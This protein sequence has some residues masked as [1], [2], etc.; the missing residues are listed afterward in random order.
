GSFIT[1]PTAFVPNLTEANG[2]VYS[3]EERRLDI[4]YPVSRNV[5]TYKLE[6]FNQ[7]GVKVFVS[8]DL[9]QG[10][11]GYYLGKCA[12]QA[13]YSYKAEGYFKDGTSFRQSGNFMLVR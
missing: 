4:F 5:D 6:I 7:W 9:Y 1:F 2:G 8:E 10:W 3:P 13:T 11:D 12:Q